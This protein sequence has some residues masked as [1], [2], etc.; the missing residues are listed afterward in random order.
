MKVFENIA[1]CL[2]Y[3]S[4]A[5]FIVCTLTSLMLATNSFGIGI[6]YEKFNI[7]YKK[8]GIYFCLPVYGLSFL[9]KGISE[10]DSVLSF[11]MAGIFFLLLI[12]LIIWK[13][14]KRK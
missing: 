12:I 6:F 8:V 4:L 5:F 2:A 11:V 1:T 9:S 7:F 14:K 3:L 10:K 13:N